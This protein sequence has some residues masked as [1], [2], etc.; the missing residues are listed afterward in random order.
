MFAVAMPALGSLPPHR[1][2]RR[3]TRV[4]RRRRGLDRPAKVEAG[5]DHPQDEQEPCNGAEGDAHDRAGAEARPAA[6]RGGDNDDTVRGGLARKEGHLV[7]AR[8][9]LRSQNLGRV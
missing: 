4:H 5:V 8:A 9:C 2:D 3:G 1:D 6:V 7:L